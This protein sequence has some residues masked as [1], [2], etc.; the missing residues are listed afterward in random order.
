MYL[1]SDMILYIESPKESIKKQLELMSSRFKVRY[2][3]TGISSHWKQ[4]IAKQSLKDAIWN[5]VKNIWGYLTNW[6]QELNNFLRTQYWKI[7][8]S[9]R[10]N[11]RSK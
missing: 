1:F 11:R 7:L 2:K 3:V 9:E 10:N 6:I 4:T 8:I 5:H